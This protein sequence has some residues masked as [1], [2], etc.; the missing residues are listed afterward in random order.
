MNKATLKKELTNLGIAVIGNYIRK[1]DIMD[2]LGVSFKVGCLTFDEAKKTLGEK[3]SLKIGNNTWLIKTN[4]GYGIKYHN[5]TIIEI[6]P[7]DLYSLDVKGWTTSTTKERIN[8]LS[9]VR[10]AQD[11][12]QWYI[13]PKGTWDK[14]TRI[15]WENGMI[16]NKDGDVVG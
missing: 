1:T 15:P 13:Y 12:G 2:V 16:V 11:K 8:T 4:K 14:K 7:H 5:T 3:E 10:V 9:P 6:L